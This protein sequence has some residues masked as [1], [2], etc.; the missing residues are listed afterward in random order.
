MEG[1]WRSSPGAPS[2]PGNH[3]TLAIIKRLRAPIAAKTAATATAAACCRR[4][5]ARLSWHHA[6]CRARGRVRSLDVG[7]GPE[8]INDR[9][10]FYCPRAVVRMAAEQTEPSFPHNNQI[11]A[12]IG[13]TFGRGRAWVTD[14]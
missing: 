6:G 3:K 8:V 9:R 2:D 7:G 11:L 13:T 4:S 12:S 5:R 10:Q 14:C 1:S